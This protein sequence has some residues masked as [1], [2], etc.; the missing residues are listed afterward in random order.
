MNKIS[1]LELEEIKKDYEVFKAENNSVFKASFLAAR[2]HNFV[3]LI[4]AN[5]LKIPSDEENI[6]A[7][8]RV[9]DL[10]ILVIRIKE[11]EKPIIQKIQT[12]LFYDEL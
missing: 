9:N 3:E 11:I 5:L 10:C 8:T 1:A 4:P 6:V 7:L 2:K 12:A